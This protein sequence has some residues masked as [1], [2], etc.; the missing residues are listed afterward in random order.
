MD[1]CVPTVMHV[2][3]ECVYIFVASVP[4][5]SSLPT[6]LKLIFVSGHNNQSKAGRGEG[7]RKMGLE[8]RLYVYSNVHVLLCVL[9]FL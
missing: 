4:G 7:E 1:E 6:L 3:N 5:A 8:L 2:C 9:F